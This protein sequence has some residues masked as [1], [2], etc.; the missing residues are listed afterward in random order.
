[1]ILLTFLPLRHF[2][3]SCGHHYIMVNTRNASF[4]Q[5]RLE[6]ALLLAKLSKSL[7]QKLVKMV[8]PSYKLFFTGTQ[9]AI[10][11][12]CSVDGSE[13]ERMENKRQGQSKYDDVKYKCEDIFYEIVE[14]VE[15]AVQK[16]FWLPLSNKG[17][18]LKELEVTQGPRNTLKMGVS[19]EGLRLETSINGPPLR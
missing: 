4:R 16:E 14:T 13:N 7:L 2:H 17:Q 15:A 8:K 11:V 9:F 1:M 6:Q 10:E 12:L 18:Q 3:F 19:I 5:G